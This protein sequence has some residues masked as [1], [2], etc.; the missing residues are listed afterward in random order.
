MAAPADCA[1]LV[2]APRQIYNPPV[3][4]EDRN[5]VR[6]HRPAAVV[7]MIAAATGVSFHA[8][9]CSGVVAQPVPLPRARP[10]DRLDAPVGRSADMSGSNPTLGVSACQLRLS[11]ARVSFKALG[12]IAGPGGCGGPDIVELER[13]ALH[14]RTEVAIEPPATLRCETAET[15]ASFVQSA[16]APAVASAGGQLVAIDNFD[17]YECRGRN[18][19]AGAKLSEHGRANAL[20]IHA[21]RLRDG[22]ILHPTDDAVALSFRQAMKA[23]ACARF[24]TVLGPGSDGY[25]EDHVHVDLAERASGYRLCQ[26]DLHEALPADATLA[27]SAAPARTRAAQNAALPDPVPLPRVRPFAF[28]ASRGMPGT[29]ESRHR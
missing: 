10:I 9:S 17:S 3:R 26:W 20:D 27:Q 24:T 15:I 22:R 23:A 28:A 14:D 11:A 2:F 19:V 25:H 1:C 18:R 21:L 29:S 6:L 4:S 7:A 8:A 16:L 5:K 12:T 13:V